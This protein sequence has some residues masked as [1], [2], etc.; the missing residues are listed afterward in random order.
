MFIIG[1]SIGLYSLQKQNWFDNISKKKKKKFDN[2]LIVSN[3]LKAYIL[4]NIIE[5]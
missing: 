4:S 2:K 5:E 1:Q 3:F